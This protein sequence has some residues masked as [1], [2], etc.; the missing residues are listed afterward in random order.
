MAAASGGAMGLTASRDRRHGCPAM[1]DDTGST[2][3]KQ[4]NSKALNRVVSRDDE[5]IQGIKIYDIGILEDPV[6]GEK[7]GRGKQHL[8][9]SYWIYDMAVFIERAFPQMSVMAKYAYDRAEVHPGY[10][11]RYFIN[12][13]NAL[14]LKAEAEGL[15]T[16]DGR[17]FFLMA[18]WLAM[19]AA[20]V[21]MFGY[22]KYTHEQRARQRES[23]Y[24]MYLR[25]ECDTNQVVW[26]PDDEDD[27]EV[28]RILGKYAIEGCRIDM[29][30]SVA[31]ERLGIH[32]ELV[33]IKHKDPTD[34]MRSGFPVSARIDS[35]KRQYESLHAH[36]TSEDHLAHLIWGFMAVMHVVALFPQKNDLID[37]ERIRRKNVLA[38]DQS[39]Q[40]LVG[41]GGFRAALHRQSARPPKL[42]NREH[43]FED[44]LKE[45]EQ[46]MI[47]KQ[48][49]DAEI[50]VTVSDPSLKDNPLIGCSVGFTKLTGYST[51]EIVGKNCRFLVDP[52]PKERILNAQRD[53]ARKYTQQCQN[54]AL[55]EDNWESGP[56][57]CCCFQVN[58]RKDRTL[59]YNMFLMRF[60]R[61][62]DKPYI[63]ALQQEVPQAHAQLMIN[64]EDPVLLARLKAR[65]EEVL[66]RISMVGL[67]ENASK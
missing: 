30:P 35:M 52:V 46:L 43:N 41:D 67:N 11:F 37:F 21:D 54:V 5:Y 17:D 50:S 9:S 55:M 14:F 39:T 7:R 31:L 51:T 25:S 63:V 36:D 56:G 13:S 61:I 29:I 1:A 60:V 59:F 47:H 12:V 26:I 65:L 34:W 42:D 2:V 15:R 57:D 32:N 48:I 33:S 6:P 64:E 44:W 53:K 18:C 20:E 45:A 10:D 16:K 23:F 27:P 38:A 28:E 66:S 8:T 24:K 40:E 22:A 19:A 3:K 4:S 49:D 58:C 62:D